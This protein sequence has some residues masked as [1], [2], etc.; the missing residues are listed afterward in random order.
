M[1]SLGIESAGHQL[2]WQC[3]WKRRSA[4]AGSLRSSG[5]SGSPSTLRRAAFHI[6]WTLLVM[7]KARMSLE[8]RARCSKSRGRKCRTT[9]DMRRMMSTGRPRIGTTHL[10]DN[11][12]R[13]V[14]KVSKAPSTTAQATACGVRDAGSGLRLGEPPAIGHLYGTQGIEKPR[15]STRG[16]YRKRDGN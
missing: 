10:E 12:Q 16:L 8:T 11:V 7:K 9:C 1:L 13:H 3:F 14:W 6:H 15:G 5:H 4:Y 2:T